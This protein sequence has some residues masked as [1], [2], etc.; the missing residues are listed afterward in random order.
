MRTRAKSTARSDEQQAPSTPPNKSPPS[1]I[2]DVYYTSLSQEIKKTPRTPKTRRTGRTKH[3]VEALVTPRN[4]SSVEENQTNITFVWDLFST[5][6][7][8]WDSIR[9]TSSSQGSPERSFADQDIQ[10]IMRRLN[11][12]VAYRIDNYKVEDHGY[13][14]SSSPGGHDPR[15]QIPITEEEKGELQLALFP[16]LQHLVELTRSQPRRIDHNMCYLDQFRALHHNLQDIWQFQ[17]HAKAAPALFQLEAWKGG[18]VNWRSSSYST[19]E[20]RF[21]ASLIDTHLQ[22]WCDEMPA[23]SPIIDY[24]MPDIDQSDLEMESIDPRHYI[25]SS[26]PLRG[27]SS[28]TPQKGHRRV[29]SALYDKDRDIGFLPTARQ[30]QSYQSGDASSTTLAGL[31]MSDPGIIDIDS[32]DPILEAYQLRGTSSIRI[33][34]EGNVTPPQTSHPPGYTSSQGSVSSNKENDRRLMEQVMEEQR[35]EN[36]REPSPSNSQDNID[37]A[38]ESWAR[39]ER[40]GE[41]WEMEMGG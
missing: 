11:R 28:P 20:E 18:I 27:C 31:G 35:L 30:I 15:E 6:R 25:D 38:N 10:Q 3:A 12:Q 5:D 41:V 33:Y 21:S 16:S 24:N 13:M 9:E 34:E 37:P 32:S 26:S 36:M 14:S 22:K 29:M 2:D 39:N 17:G 8:F 40:L 19:G 4:Q 1:E 7:S 23:P